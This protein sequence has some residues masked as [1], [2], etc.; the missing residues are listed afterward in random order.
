MS[1][2]STLFDSHLACVKD[3]ETTLESATPQFREAF[4]EQEINKDR[5]DKIIHL[6]D[7]HATY[8]QSLKYEWKDES[9]KYGGLHICKWIA[10]WFGTTIY[11]E[12]PDKIPW[13]VQLVLELERENV[14]KLMDFIS[15][16]S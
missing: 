8:F 13:R 11:Q 15:Q 3:L 12:S 14:K 1:E 6:F 16:D 9:V 7:P 2:G 10:W 5:V 4:W